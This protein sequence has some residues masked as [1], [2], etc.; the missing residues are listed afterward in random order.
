MSLRLDRQTIAR[1]PVQSRIGRL[2]ARRAR[3]YSVDLRH[4]SEGSLAWVRRRMVHLRRANTPETIARAPVQSRIGRLVAR[5][6]C[7]YSV[8]LRHRSEGSLAWVR[9]RMVH[10]RRAK[11]SVRAE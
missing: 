3:C 7:C 10:L 6:A 2:V 11:T 5:R 9:R 4:R 1:A 8:D